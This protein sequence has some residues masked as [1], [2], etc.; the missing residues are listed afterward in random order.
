MRQLLQPYYTITSKD[1]AS[2]APPSE[3]MPL[4][5]FLSALLTPSGEDAVS[6][7]TFRGAKVDAE[8]FLSDN[9]LI[10]TNL[11]LY[12][13]CSIRLPQVISKFV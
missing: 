11:L 13:T 8:K 6:P 12:V 9:N 1:H 10:G 7:D 5:T 3:D 4:P 2:S